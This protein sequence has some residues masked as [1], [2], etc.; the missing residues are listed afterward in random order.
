[1][2]Q[3]EGA[4]THM[5]KLG[6]SP[7]A[8]SL[9]K[10]KHASQERA[11][12]T[13]GAIVEAAARILASDGVLALTTNRIA[14]VAGVSIG[15]VYQYFP[16]K[17]AIVVALIEAQLQKDQQLFADVLSALEAA[18]TRP[19]L[20]VAMHHIVVHLCEHQHRLAPLLSALLPLL[21]ALRQEQIV[22]AR[23]DEMCRTL[24]TFLNAY[25]HE[26]RPAL[27][28][29]E[30]RARTVR[31]LADA[32]RGAVNAAVGTPDRLSSPAFQADVCALALGAL[33]HT[34]HPDL[35]RTFSND[36]SKP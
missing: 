18:P 20:A 14:R 12:A 15:S 25:V 29:A 30:N 36:E 5:Q 23:L 35:T 9:S 33:Q 2:P 8:R 34:P 3:G 21:P 1:M 6:S 16:N 32:F 7:P 31:V 13:V 4:A 19:S 26:L 11:E 24:E 10:R 27:H 28:D 22:Q 17:E